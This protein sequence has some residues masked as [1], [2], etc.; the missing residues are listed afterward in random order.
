MTTSMSTTK[1]HLNTTV[2]AIFPNVCLWRRSLCS[3]LVLTLKNCIEPP[4]YARTAYVVAIWPSFL[5]DSFVKI[6]AT[7][8]IFLGKWFT[9]PPWQKISRTPM[10]NINRRL[11]Y[12]L[13]YL[14]VFRWLYKLLSRIFIQ[15]K[16]FVKNAFK[17]PKKIEERLAK[18]LNG[19]VAIEKDQCKVM[20]D[21]RKL[22]E[23]QVDI[24]VHQL[25]HHLLSDDIK[26]CF[27]EW[28]NEHAP[29]KDAPWKEVEEHVNAAF[30]RRFLAIVDQWEEENKVFSNTSIF[31]MEQF[32]NHVNNV[33]FKLQNVQ[34]EAADDHSSNP[35]K[36]P[37]R[38]K[39]SFWQKAIWNIKNLT[40]GVVRRIIR[41]WME[42]PI[43]ESMK[44]DIQA[45][46]VKLLYTDLLEEV[47][48]GIFTE[49]IK[50]KLKPFVEG[51][52]KDAKLYLDRIEA[53]L[54]ELI[55][56]DRRLYKQLSKR[57][58][59]YKPVFDEVTQHRDQLAKFGLSEVCAVKIDREELEWKEE[60]SSCLGRGAS[61]AVYQGTMKRDGEVK[62]VALKVWNEARDAANAKDIMEEITNLR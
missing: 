53:R 16:V 22:F 23:E 34:R 60:G 12:E 29:D 5:F 24:V 21:L 10:S 37:F 62:N 11:D 27:T 20:K 61:S 36:V 55:E 32:Q 6:W 35:N 48:K 42:A 30:S 8:E 45:S 47:S 4:S 57:P 14:F 59:C 39:V 46:D 18:T 40:L 44:S 1:F 9:A 13:K 25:S 33:A 51:K 49:R 3:D 28:F 19:L 52:L 15:A 41:L 7:C 2:V 43:D 58:A 56:A 50:K 26:K 38:I 31:L 17:S 54:Q